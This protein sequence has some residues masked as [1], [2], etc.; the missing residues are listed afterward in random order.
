M[1]WDH[2]NPHI[3]QIV[4]S[5]DDIDNM[6][7]TNNAC[8]VVW[9]EQCAWSHSRKLGLSVTDYRRL[10]RGVAIRHAHYDYELPSFVGE[11]LEVGTWLV[12]C[13]GRLRLERRFQIRHR[14]SGKT[15]LRGHWVLV[16]INLETGKPTRFPPEFVAIYGGAVVK[17]EG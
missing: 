15:V 12:H 10:N 7:H 16:G 14:D 3:E 4:V 11:A 6:G 8:Y 13:D 17:P 9:C 1:Q 5:Q 2:A